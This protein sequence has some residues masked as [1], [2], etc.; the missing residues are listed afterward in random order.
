[1]SSRR[2]PSAA[3]FASSSIIARNAAS[4]LPEPVGALISVFVP[5]PI[6]AQALS[7]TLVGAGKALRNQAATAGWKLAGSMS[8]AYRRGC[9]CPVLVGYVGLSSS[10]A[11]SCCLRGHGQDLWCSSNR[12]RRRP[13]EPEAARHGRAED[14]DRSGA[15]RRADRSRGPAR[16]GARRAAL[17]RGVG[18]GDAP[19]G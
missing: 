1:V 17:A 3:C 7:C 15:R 10:F 4:V 12:A 11:G 13:I 16:R 5:A 2:R 6:A 18:S 9:L 19:R 14:R 8:S